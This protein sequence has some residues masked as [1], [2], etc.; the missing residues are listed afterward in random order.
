VAVKHFHN[1]HIQD[2]TLLP[3]RHRRPRTDPK[4]ASA[5][6]KEDDQAMLLEAFDIL[7]CCVTTPTYGQHIDNELRK[8]D[9]S[10]LVPLKHEINNVIFEADIGKYSYGYYT[11]N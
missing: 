10:I 8:Y 6:D 9:P 4:S 5:G 11:Q 1:Q 7:K 2:T 3:P